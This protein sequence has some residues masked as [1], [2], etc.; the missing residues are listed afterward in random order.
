MKPK[1]KKLKLKIELVPSISWGKNL[2]K[3][4][5]K[6]NWDKIRKTTYANCR[7]KCGICGAKSKLNC[8]EIWEY[9]DEKHNQKLKSFIALCDVCHR[10][11]HIG[12]AGIL[13]L[14]GKLDY[15]KTVE[16]FIKANNCNEKTFREHRES[17]F[18][19]FH[20]RSKHEWHIDL[21]EYKNLIQTKYQDKREIGVGQDVCEQV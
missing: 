19:K 21:G 9:D 16:H 10:V 1:S 13:A 6:K 14:E 15:E 11:K 2:R 7:Y 8:H 3:S 4:I 17:A 12:Q 20:E 18:D 5:T